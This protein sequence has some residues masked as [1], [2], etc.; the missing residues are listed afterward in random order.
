MFQFQES[1]FPC[2]N[3]FIFTNGCAKNRD[4]EILLVLLEF[5]IKSGNIILNRKYYTVLQLDKENKQ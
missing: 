3:T 1:I 5:K 2:N 4:N